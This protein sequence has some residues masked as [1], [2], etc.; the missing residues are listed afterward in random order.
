MFQQWFRISHRYRPDVL[1]AAIPTPVSGL[2]EAV[3]IHSCLHITKPAPIHDRPVRYFSVRNFR[4]LIN[5]P[6]AVALFPP[7]R[8]PDEIQLIIDRKLYQPLQTI[9]EV[10][11]VIIQ[12]GNEISLRQRKRFVAC[13]GARYHPTP[14]GIR[15]ISSTLGQVVEPQAWI[16]DLRDELFS[17]VGA[18]IS[19]NDQFKIV[20]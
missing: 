12:L 6:D 18:A 8:M 9:R 11:I 4:R 15:R 7:E 16:I 14:L 2:Q 3:R 13:R 19:D 1:D 20:F 5:D 17:I 10:F